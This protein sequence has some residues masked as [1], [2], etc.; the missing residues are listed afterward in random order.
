MYAHYRIFG[1]KGQLLGTLGVT[2]PEF[3]G[4]E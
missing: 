2:P 3:V 1:S 4:E